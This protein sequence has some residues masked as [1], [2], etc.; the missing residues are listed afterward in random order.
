MVPPIEV[1]DLQRAV[2]EDGGKV[3]GIYREPYGG[4]WVAIAALP[5]DQVEP[6]PFQRNLSEAHVR[7]LETAIGRLGC[8]F[9]PI[10]VVRAQGATESNVKYWTPN[11]HHWALMTPWNE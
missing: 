7:K 5:I 8:F 11:G 2:E 4:S 3:L 6:T 10:V 1:S 9:D